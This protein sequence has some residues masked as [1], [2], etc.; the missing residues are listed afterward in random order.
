MESFDASHDLSHVLRVR[1]LAISIAKKEKHCDLELVEMAALLHDVNDHKY[2]KKDDENKKNNDRIHEILTKYNVEHKKVE[3]MN[4]IIDNMSFSKEIKLKQSE[5]EEQYREYLSLFETYPEM[6]CVQ[7][8]DRLDA[9]GA[10][11]IAR[12]FCFGGSRGRSLFNCAVNN[13]SVPE[14]WI[15]DKKCGESTI[16]HFYDKLLILKDMMKTQTGKEMAR[17]R[18]KMMEIF[19]N[20]FL[21][22]WTG[23]L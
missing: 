16:G 6:G 17:E 21:K 20:T 11:G 5:N 7:D 14:E 10:I 19:V 23:S 3:A 4:V 13:E 9:M 8:A 22:E 1:N 12:T 15:A 2:I 18:H